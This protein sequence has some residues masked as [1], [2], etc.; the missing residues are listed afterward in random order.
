M[1]RIGFT[2]MPWRAAARRSTMKKLK[3]SAY[4]LKSESGVVRA[5]RINI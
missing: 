3:T 2:V 4:L 1:L 5:S